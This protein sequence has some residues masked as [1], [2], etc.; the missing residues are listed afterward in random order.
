M[1]VLVASF[2]ASSNL[3]Y[4]GLKVTVKAQSMMRPAEKQTL[5]TRSTFRNTNQDHSNDERTETERTSIP[6]HWE[7]DPLDWESDP[8]DWES[9]PLATTPSP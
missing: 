8:L 7:S 9:D 5:G 3:S 2:T 4:F 6:L 1:P